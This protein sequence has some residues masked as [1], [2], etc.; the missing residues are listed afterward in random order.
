[1]QSWAD[2]EIAG[3]GGVPIL[4]DHG[5]RT[6]GTTE[7]D[8]ETGEQTGFKLADLSRC[9]CTALPRRVSGAILDVELVGK[10]SDPLVWGAAD[11]D[12]EGIF[13]ISVVSTAGIFTVSF[14][15]MIDAFPAFECYARFEAETKEIFT[16]RPPCGNTVTDL[17]GSANRPIAGAVRFP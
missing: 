5:H 10:A 9:K 11:I 2:V 3:P 8:L 12:Y 17:L 7:V 4:I 14:S 15:G 13:K 1:M 16:A 6:S